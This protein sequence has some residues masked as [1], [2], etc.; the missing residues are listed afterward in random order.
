MAYGASC[1]LLQ[2]FLA[3]GAPPSSSPR[4]TAEA[5]EVIAAHAGSV[6]VATE[7]ARFL[8]LAFSNLGVE[9]SHFNTLPKAKSQTRSLV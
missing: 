3:M 2:G 1:K 6:A 5:A 7:A 4:S 8:P 9:S